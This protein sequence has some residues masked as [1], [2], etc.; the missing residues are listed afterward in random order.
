MTNSFVEVFVVLEFGANSNF[1]LLTSYGWK[2]IQQS[3]IRK[4][5]TLTD[6]VD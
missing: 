5:V 6:V 3:N 1:S 4:E 2:K